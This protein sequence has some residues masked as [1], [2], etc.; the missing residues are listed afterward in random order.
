MSMLA[1]DIDGHQ[2]HGP[3]PVVQ[4]EDMNAA[5]GFYR[6]VLGF[7]ITDYFLDPPIHSIVTR[8]ASQVFFGKGNDSVGVS[9]RSLKPAGIDAYFRVNGLD[10]LVDEISAKGGA[11]LEGPVTRSY[12]I[13]E[14]V[15]K[16]CNGFVLVFGED[17]T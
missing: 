8:G 7:E 10:A 2:L 14:L 3:Q 17:V 9:N 1:G 12:N 13:R 15:V 4:V 16:D 6:D 11:I 5:I